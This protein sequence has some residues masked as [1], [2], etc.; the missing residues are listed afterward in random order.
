MRIT[1]ESATTGTKMANGIISPNVS[2]WG[3]PLILLCLL[4]LILLSRSDFFLREL[5]RSG[6][7]RVNSHQRGQRMRA[8]F[9]EPRNEVADLARVAADIDQALRHFAFFRRQRVVLCDLLEI[10]H[11]PLH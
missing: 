8:H 4:W 11:E 5:L 9:D 2:G 1:E 7:R 3:Q 6:I 10:R